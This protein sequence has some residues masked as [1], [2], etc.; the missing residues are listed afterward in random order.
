MSSWIPKE[1]QPDEYRQNQNIN[2]RNLTDKPSE[3]YYS[4]ENQK[5]TQG[6]GL[7]TF[8]ASQ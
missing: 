7:F 4:R 3:A 6:G 8:Q 5:I 2:L 1:Y